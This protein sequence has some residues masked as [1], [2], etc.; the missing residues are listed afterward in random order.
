MNEGGE[1]I[2]IHFSSFYR[3]STRDEIKKILREGFMRKKT[4]FSIGFLVMLLV[5]VFLTGTAITQEKVLMET[6][7]P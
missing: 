1:E 7:G 5:L 4:V 2:S 3:K 6:R